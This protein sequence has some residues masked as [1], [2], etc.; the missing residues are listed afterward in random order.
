M[1]HGLTSVDAATPLPQRCPD[2]FR[3]GDVLMKQLLTDRMMRA[4]KPAPK[5]KRVVVVLHGEKTRRGWGPLTDA[6][7]DI[8]AVLS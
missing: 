6:Q 4:L 2:L 5:G 8:A 7:L 3:W 1:E